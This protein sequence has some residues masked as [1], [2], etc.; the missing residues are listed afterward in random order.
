MKK[1][2][3]E[4]FSYN[5]WANEV[6]INFLSSVNNPPQKTIDI[7][8]HIISAQELWLER[9]IGKHD[10]SIDLWEMLTL[11]E[12]SLMARQSTDD[13]L[14]LIRKTKEKDFDRF[15]KYK[16]PD[17]KQRENILSEIIIH[18]VNHA[19]YHRSQIN[20]IMKQNN[21]EPVKIDFIYYTRL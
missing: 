6:I 1:L 10:Y 3:I 14:K 18:V 20:M 5:D 4:L 2:F 19:T 11:Q 16:N 7:M 12:C 17:G 21:F 13:W 8:S 15:I 9:I